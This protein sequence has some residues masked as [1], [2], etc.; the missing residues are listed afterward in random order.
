MSPSKKQKLVHLDKDAST[1][2]YAALISQVESEID[3]EIAMRVRLTEA[4]ALRIAWA[5]SLQDA[6]RKGNYVLFAA[7]VCLIAYSP[8]TGNTSSESFRTTALNTLS[9]LEGPTH[10]ITDPDPVPPPSTTSQNFIRP[11]PRKLTFTSNQVEF[12]Y[13]RASSLLDDESN[14]NQLYILKCPM[15]GRTAFSKLQGILNHARLRHSL[16]W[17]TH[18]EC[19]RACAVPDNSIDTN[20]G[21][22]VGITLPDIRTLFRNAVV[23][24]ATSQTRLGEN[25]APT[26]DDNNLDQQDTG[27]HLNQTLGLHAD[28]SSLA[29]FL[30]K[31]VIRREIKMWDSD[32]S[33]EIE[34]ETAPTRANSQQH[35][36]R[37]PFAQRNAGD[38]FMSRLDQPPGKQLDSKGDVLDYS[39]PDVSLALHVD[40]VLL[41]M[42]YIMLDDT[43]CGPSNR[44]FWPRTI[45]LHCTHHYY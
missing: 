25:L 30:G 15:C 6:I 41:Y 26:A 43:H 24:K 33:V 39:M 10:F 20:L 14:V 9:M 27:T 11:P 2:D 28:T 45:P 16:E 4:L 8:G 37:M 35:S 21:V 32:M 38:S 23:S 29:P 40:L 18:D 5:E 34:E 44:R 22:E 31:D 1:S 7:S 12:L 13:T 42:F 17:G 3:L 19:I 36:W